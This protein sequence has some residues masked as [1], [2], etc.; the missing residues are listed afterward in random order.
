MS[1]VIFIF[2]FLKMTFTTERVYEALAALQSNE[3]QQNMQASKWLAEFQESVGIDSCDALDL[4]LLVLK[5]ARDFVSFKPKLFYHNF[6][7]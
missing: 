7:I 2:H 6:S 3:I 1:E 4:I 5:I